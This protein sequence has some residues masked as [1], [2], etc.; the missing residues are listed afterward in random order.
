MSKIS[1]DVITVLSERWPLCFCG[2]QPLCIG[3]YYDIRAA[4]PQLDDAA[5]ISA[6]GKYTRAESYLKALCATGAE[7]VNLH[8]N[9]VGPVSRADAECA[10]TIL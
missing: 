10:A 1:V 4:M 8:G 9:A 5:L 2:P 7:R 6:L 3:I